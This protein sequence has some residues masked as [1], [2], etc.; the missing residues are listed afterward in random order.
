MS[1]G[2]VATVDMYMC[3]LAGHPQW[4][5][6]CVYW[7]G[8]HSGHVHVSIGRV[9]TVDMFMC[10]LVGHPQWTCTCVYW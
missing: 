5:C 7:W 4:T 9:P 1:I 8:T 2:R 6:T 3:L 10:L